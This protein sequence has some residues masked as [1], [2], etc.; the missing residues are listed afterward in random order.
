ML[1]LTEQKL[2]KILTGNREIPLW[3]Q[4][5]DKI[6]PMF[7]INTVNRIAAFLAQTGHESLNFTVLQ[8]NLN[9]SENNLVNVFPKYFDSTNAKK[10]A[11]QPQKIASRV[12]AS[13]MG[14]GDEASQEGWK[15][16]GRSLIQVTGKS[17]YKTY[18]LKLYNDNRLEQNPDSILTSKDDMIKIACHFW[19]D[20]NLNSLADVSDITTM[21]K[22]ING[23]IIGLQDRLDRYK[24]ALVIL[25]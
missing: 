21:T 17:N 20:K 9:Y 22:R 25:K 10:Y 19:K 2:S 3:Y 6:L 12:Y 24:N 23:G 7:D 15:F 8:E 1:F 18:S 4:S 13:R 16:R 11:K 14:N 5:L